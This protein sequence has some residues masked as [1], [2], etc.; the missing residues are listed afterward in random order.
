MTQ[1]ILILIT[2]ETSHN[3]HCPDG[4][5]HDKS[6]K[7][8]VK[9]TDPKLVLQGDNDPSVNPKS[10]QLIYGRVDAS[11]R[12]LILVPSFFFFIISAKSINSV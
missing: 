1:R 10:A 4:N 5:G 7:T 11:M 12:K 2:Q 6:R 9:I 8:L 3:P